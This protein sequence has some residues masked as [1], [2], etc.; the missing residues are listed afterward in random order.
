MDREPP[1]IETVPLAPDDAELRCPACGYDLRGLPRAGRC[2]EC[3]GP[4]VAALAATPLVFSDRV[5][6]RRM[7]WGSLLVHASPV[8]VILT[9]LA[10]L[11][12][13][14]YWTFGAFAGLLTLAFVLLLGGLWLATSRNPALIERESVWSGRRVTRVA[15]LAALLGVAALA[16]TLRPMPA[17]AAIAIILG[18]SPFG[19]PGVVLV[20]SLSR[21]VEQ[22][23]R[24]AG[25]RQAIDKARVNRLAFS[26][27]AAL[28]AILL[29][30]AAYRLGGD[31][32]R[33]LLVVAGAV[34]LIF[35]LL[36]ALLPGYLLRDLSRAP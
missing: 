9:P 36:T 13:W 18:L 2:P 14:R 29:P 17:P 32:T 10:V 25:N 23:A 33:L 35:G 16:T 6:L 30:L 21:Y 22:M 34:A 19:A 28:I 15:L 7:F 11:L 27:A 8:P 5:W 3:G 26:I 12:P 1:R 4:V 20:I 24:A 31:I